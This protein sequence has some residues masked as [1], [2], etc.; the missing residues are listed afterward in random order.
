MLYLTPQ[1]LKGLFVKIIFVLFICIEFLFAQV[2]IKGEAQ[3]FS[4]DEK[5]LSIGYDGVKKLPV[6]PHPKGGYFTILPINYKAKTKSATLTKLFASGTKRTQIEITD[7][8]YKKETLSVDPSKVS[9][10][11]EALSR[12]KSEYEEAMKIYRTQTQ[13]RYWDEPF[14]YPMTSTVTSVYGNARVFNDSL[15]SYHSGTDFRAPV[16]TPV[17]AVNDG[18]VVIAKDRYYAGGSIVIDHGYGVYSVYYHL[19]SIDKN[20]GDAVKKGEDIGLSGQSGR[21]T[22]PHLHFGITVGGYA[23]NPIDFIE[24]INAT[25]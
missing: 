2:A 12:I 17:Q 25:F 15:K 8:E 24:K 16:G 9:P 10:P 18:V 1:K 3:I 11:K 6:I 20:V 7:G 5:P 14:I 13:K 4:F 21:V 22:G 19:S 23:I